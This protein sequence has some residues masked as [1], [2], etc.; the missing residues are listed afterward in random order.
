MHIVN[1][2]GYF[3]KVKTCQD[4]YHLVSCIIFPHI[5]LNLIYQYFV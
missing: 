4:G 3:L 2:I 5:L 1:V